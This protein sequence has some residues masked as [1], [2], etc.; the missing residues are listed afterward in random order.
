MSWLQIAINTTKDHAEL[1]EDRLFAAGAQTV[2][3]TDAADQPILEPGVDEAPI[4]NAVIITGLFSNN[5][6][7]QQLLDLLNQ[8]LTD[9][10]H[11]CSAEVLEDQ[12]WTR[13][14]MDHYHPMQFGERL[15]I[16]PLH[17]APP[18]A[19][20]ITLRLDPGLAFGTSTHP[21]TSLC[22]RW[23]DKNIKQQECLLDYG[24][25]SGILAIAACML[26]TAHA[27]G[28]DIDP[29]A[30]IATHDNAKT[31]QVDEKITSYLPEDFQDLHSDTQY[32]IVVAN[33]LSGPLAELAPTLAQHTKAKG[34]IVLSGILREQAD[35]VLEA[36]RDS[37]NM[38]A[39]EFDE[40]WV[41]LHGTKKQTSSKLD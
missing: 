22:L 19:D 5:N 8:S 11:T 36:Y 6:N 13:A 3:L 33:I 32:D 35:S 29:Q 12:N 14:W 2:T 39:P 38:D 34:H 16:C 40:D 37:F 18:E 10:Q 31:N 41:L 20:A 25:G 7:Q 28:V 17:L 24:C 1:A 15:W 23:L 9:I 4:W 30:L 21:T 27:D 26:G